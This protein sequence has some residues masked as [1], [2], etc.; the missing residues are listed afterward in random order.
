MSKE[1][2]FVIFREKQTNR[3]NKYSIFVT[4]N[5]DLDSK[6]IEYNLTS[7]DVAEIVTND[8]LVQLISIAEQNKK[9]KLSDLKDIEDAIERLRDDFHDMTKDL[10]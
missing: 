8:D 2:A 4:E 6:I 10:K 3:I 9:A 1:K 5:A 7:K